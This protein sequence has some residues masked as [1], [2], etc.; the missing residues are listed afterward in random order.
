MLDL[1]P[2]TETVFQPVVELRTG[3]VVGYEALLRGPSGKYENP[4]EFLKQASREGVLLQVERALAERAGETAKRCFGLKKLFFNLTPRA[5]LAVDSFA[6]VFRRLPEGQVVVELTESAPLR[7]ME[8]YKEA[9]RRW[10][11]ELKVGVAIDDIGAGYSRLL[12]IADL[13]PRYLKIDGALFRS[14]KRNIVLPSLAKMAEELGAEI[15]VEGLETAQDTAVAI[16]LGIRLGQGYYLGRP[17]RLA[18]G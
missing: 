14:S 9:S 18:T 7:D 5:F 8:Q 4:E 2:K 10:Q 3:E 13:M 16:G 1:L 17:S 12:A 11:E 6:E 15:V